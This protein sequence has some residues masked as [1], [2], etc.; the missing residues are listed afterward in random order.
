MKTVSP[1]L[2][3]NNLCVFNVNPCKHCKQV[4]QA[5]DECVLLHEGD[6]PHTHTRLQVPL[7]DHIKATARS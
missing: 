2:A 4:R 5:L 6:T 1:K 7:P 3:C